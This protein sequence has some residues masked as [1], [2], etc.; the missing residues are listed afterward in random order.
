MVLMRGDIPVW[1]AQYEQQ[2][3]YDAENTVRTNIKFNKKTD[4]DILEALEKAPK[5]QTFIKEAIR[6]YL[7]HSEDK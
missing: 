7:A 4:A 1:K 5:K 6:F 2:K 3:K